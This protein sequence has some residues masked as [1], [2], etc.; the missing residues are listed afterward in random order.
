MKRTLGQMGFEFATMAELNDAA[1]EAY[2]EAKRSVNS[3]DFP[4]VNSRGT[5]LWMTS[6]DERMLP[7]ISSGEGIDFSYTAKELQRFIEKLEA[8]GTLRFVSAIGIGGGFDGYTSPEAF[9]YRD[10]TPWVGEWDITLWKQVGQVRQ[11]TTH[12]VLDE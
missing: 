6:T 9:R 5:Q 11:E 2:Y 3:R 7:A 12:A 8:D 10:Y 4:F 1:N